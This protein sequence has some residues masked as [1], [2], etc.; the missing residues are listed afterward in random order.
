MDEN[1]NPEDTNPTEDLPASE[2]W[3]FAPP[4]DEPETDDLIDEAESEPEA[5]DDAA[6]MEEFEPDDDLREPDDFP[7]L[8]DSLDIDAALAAVSTLDDMLA[9]QEAQE[10]ARIAREQAEAEARQQRELRLKNPELFFPMPVLM[11]SQRGR[12]DSVVP[13]LVLIVRGAW[14]TFTLTTTEALPEP[15]WLLAAAAASIGVISVARW[16]A[17]G[18]WSA[19]VLFVGVLILALGVALGVLLISGT[20]VTAWPLLLTAVGTAFILVSVLLRGFD[21]RLFFPG[22]VIALAGLA[23]YAVTGGWLPGDLLATFTAF[24]PVIVVIAL[25]VLVLPGLFRRPKRG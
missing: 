5:A 19:G 15:A 16:L 24:W 6:L 4:L 21:L 17:S 3:R 22:L 23:G 20:L 13:A 1:L 2:D 11:T 10:Q 8:A 25:V 9:E 7:V 18:R 12:I 14:L